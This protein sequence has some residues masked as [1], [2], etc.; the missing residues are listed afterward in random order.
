M[1]LDGTSWPIMPYVIPRMNS[2][3]WR[4]ELPCVARDF[5][6]VRR[7]KSRERAKKGQ[8]APTRMRTKPAESGSGCGAGNIWGNNP[9]AYPRVRATPATPRYYNSESSRHSAV[10][11]DRCAK[12]RSM[13]DSIN[14][15][16]RWRRYFFGF[17]TVKISPTR[18]ASRPICRRCP[19]I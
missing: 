19:C 10:G 6:M 11:A 3:T 14:P 16:G 8:S 7:S 1:Y 9:G 17:G 18:L 12:Q 13:I 5:R 4:D 2:V 15:F